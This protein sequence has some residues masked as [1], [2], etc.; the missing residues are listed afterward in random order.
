MHT[1]INPQ[2]YSDLKKKHILWS[3][4]RSDRPVDYDNQPE[5]FLFEDALRDAMETADMNKEGRINLNDFIRV[6]VYITDA[7]IVG[8]LM[9]GPWQVIIK[10]GRQKD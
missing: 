6:S 7:N 2:T 1:I 10:K 4:F 5:L 8:G 9:F 3:L